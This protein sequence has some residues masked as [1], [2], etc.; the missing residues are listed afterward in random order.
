VH[1][2][3]ARWLLIREDAGAVDNRG[4]SES[5]EWDETLYAQSAGYYL[6]GRL[7][8]PRQ[9]AA[10]IVSAVGLGS[11]SRALDVGCGPGH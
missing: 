9:L 3:A 7:T 4:M 2:A 1:R 5:W 6:C 10:Q 11:D 8:Y